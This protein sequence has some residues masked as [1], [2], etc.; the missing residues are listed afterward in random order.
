MHGDGQE[1]RTAST[2]PLSGTTVEPSLEELLNS[3]TDSVVSLPFPKFPTE[4][5][6]GS[7]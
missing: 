3:V 7:Q 5:P 2:H 6:G 1:R 4:K